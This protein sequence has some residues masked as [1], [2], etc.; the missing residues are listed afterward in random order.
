MKKNT[1]T[2]NLL[3]R[4]TGFTLIE[5]L[6]VIAIIAILAAMLLP[7]LQQARARAYAIACV[8]NM[9][10]L[11]KGWALYVEDNAGVYPGL[12][13]GGGYSTSTRK[14]NM[15]HLVHGHT[16]GVRGSY[17]APYIGTSI[18][19]SNESGGGLGGFFKTSS[20]LLY[21]HTLFCPAR[22]GVM[23]EIIAKK[24]A[25][26]TGGNGIGMNCRD[27]GQKLSK[28]RQS[29]RSMVGGESP[30]SAFYLD[31]TAASSTEET[32]FIPVFPHFNPNPGD[33]EIGNQQ[34]ATGPG[35]TSVFFF[36][37][38]VQQIARNAFPSSNR[39]GDSITSGAYYSTFWRPI[40][41]LHNSW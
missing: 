7:A 1:A 16:R 38:H 15:S 14:W 3:P 10:T 29:S 18:T 13:N 9:G 35:A 4:R 12:W 19:T 24:G 39:I 31:R 21:K 25:A 26:A 2:N 30:F 41:Y 34:L 32:Y 11:A 5:L 17:F 37:A 27:Q 22:E 33:N 8:N 6:V 20:G 40:S 23:R 28:V 36:D